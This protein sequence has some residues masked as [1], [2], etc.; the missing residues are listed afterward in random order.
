MAFSHHGKCWKIGHPV[1]KSSVSCEYPEKWT[2]QSVANPSIS[3]LS[4][5][6]MTSATL[7][8]RMNSAAWL[9]PLCATSAPNSHQSSLW[10]TLARQGVLPVCGRNPADV[11]SPPLPDTQCK[12]LPLHPLSYAEFTLLIPHFVRDL[13]LR[14]AFLTFASRLIPKIRWVIMTPKFKIVHP[15]KTMRKEDD[16]LLLGSG[17]FL[18]GELAV[19]LR[20]GYD[21]WYIMGS[22]QAWRFFFRLPGCSSFP[23]QRVWKFLPNLPFSEITPETLH[24]QNTYTRSLVDVEKET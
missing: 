17:I 18:R 5:R 13:E 19:K 14:L 10:L 9:S 24:I 22:I 23:P 6:R 4:R 2:H 20:I 8:W 1:Q 16:H 11:I 7:F 21:P 15:L 3:I 12:L